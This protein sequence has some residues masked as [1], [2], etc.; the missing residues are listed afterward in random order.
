[1]ITALLIEDEPQLM[2]TNRLMLQQNF[3]NIE[4]VGE[5]STV[6]EAV[7]LITKKK[8]QLVLLDIELADGNCFQILNQ[9]R[10]FTFKPI[11]ITAYNN[12]AIKAIKYSAIDYI[13]KPVNEFEFCS[14]VSKAIESINED[15]IKLQTDNFSNHY[16]GNLK[17]NKIILRTSD[18]LHLTEINDILFCQSDNSYTSIYLA[19]N[20]EIIVSKSLK[21][22]TDLLGEY[23][24]IRP[25][26][27]YLVNINSIAKVDKTDGGF[28]ILK[29]GKEIPISKRRKQLVLDKLATL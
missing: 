19:D 4:I 28:I 2:E 3:P 25:H 13:L 18:A 5:A 27:S 22:F 11:F 23:D 6:T 21:E 12:H 26:Q 7:D 17:S 1:M 9:C 20:K 29:N 15:Y 8:P 24:F 10:P 14:A 16:A